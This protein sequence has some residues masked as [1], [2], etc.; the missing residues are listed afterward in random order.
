MKTTGKSEKVIIIS[1]LLLNFKVT[2]TIRMQ[3]PDTK[4]QNCQEK[5][6]LFKMFSLLVS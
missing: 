1:K 4:L 3:L 2:K 6:G 5:A